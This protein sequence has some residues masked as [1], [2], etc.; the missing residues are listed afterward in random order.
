MKTRSPLAVGS[1]LTVAALLCAREQPKA[2][3]VKEER[4]KLAGAWQAVTYELGGKAAPPEALAK[5]RLEIDGDGTATVRDDGKTFLA[6]AT[7]VD[8]SKAPKT[9]D[10]RFTEG[11]LKGQT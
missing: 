4:K 1:L 9:M 8:P 2:D 11:E 6:A 7:T 5:V 10:I 3:A